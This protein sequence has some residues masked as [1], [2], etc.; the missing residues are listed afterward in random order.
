[1]PDNVTLLRC[2]CIDRLADKGIGGLSQSDPLLRAQ[3]QPLRLNYDAFVQIVATFC[4]YS[5][6]EILQCT[7][8]ICSSYQV[9]AGP[10]LN[11]QVVSS[12][13]ACSP[14]LLP[15]TFNAYDVD[16][17]GRLDREEIQGLCHTVCNKD[18]LFPG[19]LAFGTFRPWR[20]NWIHNVMCWIYGSSLSMC[21]RRF[22]AYSPPPTDHQAT[23]RMR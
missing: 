21:C 5:R 19:G 16:G 6:A 22:F 7:Y 4:T 10:Q 13:L 17:N 3:L 9:N 18:P 1:M 11:L 23:S 12:L 20:V 2:S 14:S 8:S 15:V